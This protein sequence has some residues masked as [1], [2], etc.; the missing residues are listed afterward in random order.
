M[1]EMTVARS[2]AEWRRR[3]LTRPDGRALPSAPQPARL[4]AAGK[5]QFLVYENYD[6]LL[7]YNCAHHYALSV[8]LLADRIR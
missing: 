7:R 8:A 1:R 2:L 6:A 3:G 5:R 4:V